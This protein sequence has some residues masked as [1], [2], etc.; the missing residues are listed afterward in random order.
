MNPML[1]RYLDGDL[2][3]DQARELEAMLAS[4]PA[5]EA[6]LRAGEAALATLCAPSTVTVSAGFAAHVMDSVR[7][8][9]T[10]SDSRPHAPRPSWLNAKAL[11]LAASLA[12]CFLAGY[13]VAG[14]PRTLVPSRNDGAAVAVSADAVAVGDLRLVHLVYV[15]RDDVQ[16]VTVAGDFNGWRPEATPL[17]RANGVWT[18]DLALPPG[19]YAYMFVVD[20]GRWV[21]DPLA[22]TTRD[23]GFGGTNAVLDLSL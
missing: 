17:R 7:S 14:R 3:E 9:D 13:L 8:L 5:L 16:Q 1:E 11:A 15:P 4:D 23:D 20:G 2:T 6:E 22:R 18:L 21:T 12:V 10:A 19:E